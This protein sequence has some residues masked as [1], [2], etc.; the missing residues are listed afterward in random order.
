MSADLVV[1]RHAEQWFV[2]WP[3]KQ[4]AGPFPTNAE[5]WRWADRYEGEPVSRSEQTS[6]WWFDTKINPET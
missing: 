1:V 5:A 2:I 6:Q 3:P 4:I